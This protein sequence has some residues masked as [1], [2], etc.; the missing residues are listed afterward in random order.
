MAFTVASS[1]HTY[2]GG[3]NFGRTA[4][5]PFITTSYD[6][7]APIDE[8]G[9]LRQPKYDHL[10]ELHKAIKSSERAILSAD[11]AFVSLG[12]YEQAHVFSSKTGGCA[13]F[14][15]NYHLNSSTTVTFRKKCYTLPPWSSAFFLIARMSFLTLHRF[16]G[17][18]TSL[19]NMLPTNVNRLA[20][21]TFSEDNSRFIMTMLCCLYKM[22][23]ILKL[24]VMHRRIRAGELSNAD[25][26]NL[27]TIMANPRQFKIPYWFLKR[28]KDYKDGKYSQVTSNALDIK[29]RDDLKH[30]EKIRLI[31]YLLRLNM[32]GRQREM[33]NGTYKRASSKDRLTAQDREDGLGGT[34]LLSYYLILLWLP[35]MILEKDPETHLGFVHYHMSSVVND[36]LESISVDLGFHGVTMAEGL[37]VST[38]LGGAFFGSTISGWIA[39]GIGRRRSFQ[40][41]AIPMIISALMSATADGLGGMLLGRFLFGIGMGVTPPV[42]ALYIT[43]HLWELHSDCNMS[44]T[45]MFFL[46]WD[47]SK[48]CFTWRMCFLVSTVPAALL[49]FLME[50]YAESPHWLFKTDRGDEVDRIKLSELSYGRHFRVV[51]IGFALQQ[52][53]GIN[54]VFYFSSTVFKCAG[55]PPDIANMSVGVVNLSGS[56]VAMILMDKLGRK[57][58]LHGSFMGMLIQAMS[59]GMQAVVGSSL[60]SGLQWCTYL[61]VLSFAMSVGLVPGLLLTEIFPGRIRAK[62]MA[63]CMAVHWVINFFVGLL[64][65][66]MLEQVGPL[67]LYTVFAS[68][69][70]VGF[71]FFRKNVVETKGKTLQEIEMALL[72]ASSTSSI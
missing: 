37:V 50:F 24:Y 18:K 29:L 8:Y 10:K 19:T 3:T 59:I 62:A 49:A 25:I 12:T 36:T 51:F 53:S 48:G 16:V 45:N 1:F 60:V 2:H 9:L 21:Q 31:L 64:I 69:C 6:Y 38:C 72:P 54:V 57:A 52:F 46:H 23:V 67:I 26:D 28:K 35:G 58:L 11:P 40:F 43:E 14:T 34:L 56:I 41:C 22:D 15:T 33:I 66:R 68:F 61:F 44:W 65:L 13:A 17:T 71:V 63:I 5:G 47:T 42:A 27:M 20:W 55:V 30:L 7:N 39:D 4:G 70:L 32:R